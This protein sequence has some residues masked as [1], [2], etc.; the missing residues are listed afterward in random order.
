M[1]FTVWSFLACATSSVIAAPTL[2]V[3]LH[4][5]SN[6]KQA[7]SRGY[8]VKFKN[9]AIPH[10]NRRKWIDNQLHQ[11]G[12]DPLTDK[13]VGTLKVGWRSDVF[14]GFSGQLSEEA[15]KAFRATKDV[16][17]VAEGE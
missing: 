9:G 1:L 13:Q 4:R 15:I 17:F 11:A 2:L 6:S 5:V 7:S 8:I 10:T 3:P 16:E 14:D 12:L